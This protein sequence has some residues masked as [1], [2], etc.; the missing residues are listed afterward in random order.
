MR[1][2]RIAQNGVVHLINSVLSP[3]SYSN[4]NLVQTINQVWIS[5]AGFFKNILYFIDINLF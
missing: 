4:R 2:N 5:W 3:Y 1:K